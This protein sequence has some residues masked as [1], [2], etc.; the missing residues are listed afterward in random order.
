MR[1]GEAALNALLA[2]LAPITGEIAGG[3][4][5]RNPET[6][7]PVSESERWNL[8]T[9]DGD[10]GEPEV[11]LSPPTYEYQHE[12]ALALTVVKAGKQDADTLF[13]CVVEKISTRIAA[14]PTLG[15]KV[16][17]VQLGGLNTDEVDQEVLAGF[18]AAILPVTLYYTTTS[19]L[20]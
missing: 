13:S 3:E 20:G 5:C 17:Y 1:K 19:P 9:R 4:I 2:A 16:D 8:V 18:K 10:P 6:E 11:S 15:G 12:A 14:A 7:L